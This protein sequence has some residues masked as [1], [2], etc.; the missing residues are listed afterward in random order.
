[1]RRAAFAL[2]AFPPVR[3]QSVVMSCARDAPAKKPAQR[4]VLFC[5]VLDTLVADPFY[6]GM[7]QHFG[8]D[9]FGAFCGAK[10]PDIWVRFEKGLVDERALATQFFSDGR[11]VDVPA[12]KRFLFDQYTLL[13]G[14]ENMLTMLRDAK[15]EMHVCSNYPVWNTIIEDKLGLS[16]RF[17]MQWSF[18]SGRE[19]LRKPD[20][21]A[22]QR[23]ASIAGVDVSSCVLLDDRE[24]NLRG[25]M[26]ANFYDAVHFKDAAQAMGALKDLYLPWVTL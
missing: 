22:Y 25:A 12:L 10:T 23:A 13:P 16:E 11:A 9:S 21:E 17:G 7:A 24:A 6:R 3:A 5:D 14:V 2:G 8:F 1:M 18:V 15:V 26:D 19:G 20:I 4:P